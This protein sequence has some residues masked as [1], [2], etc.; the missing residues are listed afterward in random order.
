M[1]RQ[2]G[3]V[4]P[5]DLFQ[6]CRFEVRQGGDRPGSKRRAPPYVPGLVE[7]NRRLGKRVIVDLTS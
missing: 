6:G 2:P 5:V 4:V 3:V 1:G 7:F